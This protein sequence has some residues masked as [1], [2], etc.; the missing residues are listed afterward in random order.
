MNLENLIDDAEDY[1]EMGD[2]AYA[3]KLDDLLCILNEDDMSS[4]YAL[5][6]AI[7][8]EFATYPK[9]NVVSGCW[10]DRGMTPYEVLDEIARIMGSGDCDENAYDDILK[11]MNK[12]YWGKSNE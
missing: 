2:V 6:E 3:D 7:N 11:L 5:Q 10:E 4:A 9:I 12:E 1:R 8:K